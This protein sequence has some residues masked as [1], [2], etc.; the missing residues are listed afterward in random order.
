MRATLGT[1]VSSFLVGTTFHGVAAGSQRL[2]SQRTL[3]ALMGKGG[4]AL[5]QGGTGVS[6][7]GVQTGKVHG[8]LL[9][10]RSP[11]HFWHHSP[12]MLRDV[13]MS[14]CYQRVI[15]KLRIWWGRPVVYEPGSSPLTLAQ[16][17]DLVRQHADDGAWLIRASG[18]IHSGP[19]ALIPSSQEALTSK[20]YQEKLA[21]GKR[22]RARQRAFHLEALRDPASVKGRTGPGCTPGGSSRVW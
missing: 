1:R 12:G 19:N 6:R 13:D 14:G 10:S 2:R 9:V 7:Y 16:A 4:V 18:D 22:R 15:E 17:V 5:F 11:T 8:G 21:A 20:N 3:Q